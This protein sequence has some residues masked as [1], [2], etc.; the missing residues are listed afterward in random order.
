MKWIAALDLEKWA[1]TVGARTTFP[2]LI[3]DLI[4]ASAKEIDAYRFP[5]GD[6]GQVRGF[7]GNLVSAAAPPF[8]PG[9]SSIW[10]FGVSS[11]AS[12]KAEKDYAK[13]VKEIPRA[14]RLK[15]TFVFVSP[16]TWDNPKEKLHDW[17]EAKRARKEWAD[18]KYIDGVGVEAWLDDH[19]AV[20]ARYSRFEL[21]RY[22][23]LG[24]RSTDEFWEEYSTRFNPSLTEEV[25]L[26]DREKQ[27]E[28]FLLKL[29]EP[30]PIILAADSPDEVIAFA[31][32]AIRKAKDEVRLFLEAR[33]LI[34][35]N[36]DAVSLFAGKSRHTFFPRGQA[37]QRAGLLAK[38]APTLVAMGGDQPNK[39]Y[40]ILTRPS[41]AS[42]GKAIGTMGFPDEQGYQLARSCGRSVT[43]LSRLIPGGAA[44]T[45]EWINRGATLI[46]ALLAGGWTT[47]SSGDLGV[48]SRLANGRSYAEFEA[49]LRPFTRLQD[50]PIDRV[51]DVW[52]IRAPVDAFVHLG[53]LIGVDDLQRLKNA[54]TDVFSRVEESPNPDDLFQLKP[55]ASEGSSAW[56]REGLATTLLQIAT[57]H[58][59]A[60]LVIPGSTPQNYVN[61]L[62]R[63]L[64]GLSEDHRLLAS[65]KNEL[66][67]LAEAAPD[68]LL[69]AL[70]HLLEGDAEKIRPIFS[71]SE[72]LL[73][74]SSA[75]TGLLWALETLAWDPLLLRRV[76]LVLARL[77]AIDPG[78]RLLNRPINTLRQI[79]L[80]WLPNTNANVQ[81]RLAVLDYIIPRLPTV[82]WDLL[83][84]LFPR[85]SD[86]STPSQ[87]PRFREAGASERETLTYAVVWESQRGIVS[88]ALDL[89]GDDPQRLA[90]IIGA[91]GNFEPEQRL[92]ALGLIDT[93]LGRAAEGDHRAIWLAL[94]D[95]VNRNRAFSDADW[96]LPPEEL[97]QLELVVRRHQPNNPIDPISWLFDDWTP[98]LADSHDDPLNA[99]EAARRKA[100]ENLLTNT[101]IDG[102]LILAERVK[103]PQCVATAFAEINSSLNDY[104]ALILRA[105]SH[106]ELV[107]FATVLS[108]AAK[109]KF[110]SWPSRLKSLAD[111]EGWSSDAIASLMLAWPDNR[112][113]WMTVKEFGPAI[114][115]GY[116]S[117][118]YPF[119]PEGDADDLGFAARRYMSAGRAT[120]AIDAVHRRIGEIPINLVFDMLDAVLSE[121]STSKR[122]I[123]NMLVYHL[124]K[125]FEVLENRKDV[126]IEEIARREYAY[127]PLLRHRKKPLVLHRIMAESPKFYVSVI[128]DTF[129][130]ASAKE[131]ETSEEK[132]ARA[133]A[134]YRLLSSFK[135][136]PGEDRGSVDFGTLQTWT[137][138]VRQEAIEVDRAR[139]ADQYI[140]H[141]LAHAPLDKIDNFWPD[142]SVRILLEQLDSD[143]VENG[144][145]VERSNMR[146]PHWRSLYE[147]GV[148]ERTLAEQYK[149]W[150]KGTANWP[151]TSATLQR[152]AQKYER[153]AEYEDIRAQQDKLK[154]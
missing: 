117:Q 129:K 75:H 97:E 29:A 59:P 80:S 22:P 82:S 63:A 108:G 120:A 111:H 35:D 43:I 130:A 140:G 40:E 21:G 19:P 66:A 1:E 107:Q 113:T 126:A 76:T 67:L 86:T 141:I 12:A 16:R 46:P 23:K 105:L 138:G 41:S 77:A 45:P 58:V 143:D 119:P 95:E 55:K 99:V 132:R 85:D 70:E 142:Q 32:A 39:N 98:D 118:K 102:V 71:E 15:T 36:E 146:G 123:S 92:R 20:A 26:C 122:S 37:R 134:G 28:Q 4:R 65:L 5:S 25:L 24:A 8:V 30:G 91:L 136:V 78:G 137:F 64:P 18:V 9:G 133:S 125:I 69:S 128:S 96:S 114:E 83:V 33:T 150:A 154:D 84:K 135:S 147:G 54:A 47:T 17:I 101:G 73:A 10:E 100:I 87:T 148:Q 89:A 93:Y 90:T 51:G 3:G 56:L 52:K 149:I 151:R 53:H 48:L 112:E 13:R 74:P 57:L 60:A 145:L 153:D 104:E 106:S 11:N 139:V 109:R 124:E 34:I 38:T 6:K 94:R 115:D 31:V 116:W 27:A 121:I 14:T 50:P 131:E 42:L 110:V 44:E 68:P 127:L 62:V 144:L 81:Q 2:A 103:L 61:E 7:D 152:I 79:F 88:R 72:H 49:D